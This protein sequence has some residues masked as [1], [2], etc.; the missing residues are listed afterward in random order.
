MDLRFLKSWRT[1]QIRWFASSELVMQSL[2]KPLVSPCSFFA[3]LKILAGRNNEP[4]TTGFDGQGPFRPSPIIS[5][6][7][8]PI[9]EIVSEYSGGLQVIVQTELYIEPIP[10]VTTEFERVLHAC[11]VGTCFSSGRNSFSRIW[12]YLSKPGM[13]K[14]IGRITSQGV[15]FGSQGAAANKWLIF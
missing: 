8:Q 1:R 9:F 3:L 4:E 10:R 12:T 14:V 11:P 5:M 15:I 7:W 6:E 2:Q 13:S